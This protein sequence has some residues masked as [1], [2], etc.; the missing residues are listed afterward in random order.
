MGAYHDQESDPGSHACES[1]TQ[2]S[3]LSAIFIH[4][5]TWLTHI[6]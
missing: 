4:G 3:E 1:N 5:A 6:G 2:T